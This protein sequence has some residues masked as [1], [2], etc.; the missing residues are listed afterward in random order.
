MSLQSIC[1][2]RVKHM[3]H[4]CETYAISKESHLQRT[5]KK[6]IKQLEQMLPTYV[7]NMSN[8]P[9]YF[10]NIHLKHLQ[11]TSKTSKNN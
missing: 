1:N 2:V 6:Q 7:Y 10:Y 9:I 8:I 4:M 11:H 5:S 3:Q